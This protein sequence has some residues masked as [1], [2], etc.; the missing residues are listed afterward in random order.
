MLTC[1]MLAI[2][3]MIWILYCSY[4][5]HKMNKLNNIEANKNQDVISTIKMSYLLSN[6]YY[7]DRMEDLAGLGDYKKFVKKQIK[8]ELNKIGQ[9]TR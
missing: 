1:F 2:L 3:L 9:I 6:I 5:E 8:K 7:I 4:F